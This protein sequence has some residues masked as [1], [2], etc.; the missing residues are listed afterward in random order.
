MSRK[1]RTA[2]WIL[3]IIAVCLSLTPTVTDTYSDIVQ[4]SVISG[5]ANTF[6]SMTEEEVRKEKA[7]A[8]PIMHGWRRNS[9]QRHLPIRDKRYRLQ[10]MNRFCL[11][12]LKEQIT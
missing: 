9:L 4:I 8:W 10:N 3:L 7:D 6:D 1:M 12:G 2:I 11:R 5:N